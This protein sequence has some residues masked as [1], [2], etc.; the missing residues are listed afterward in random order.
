MG[1]ASVT[2]LGL[3]VSI[4]GDGTPTGQVFAG[5][6][7]GE[8]FIFGSEDGTISGWHTGTAADTLVPGSTAAVYKGVTLAGSGSDMVLLGANFRAGTIDVFSPS[9]TPGGMLTMVGQF[10]DP[11]APAGYA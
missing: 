2:K 7:N 1:M 10:S 3:I 11:K 4:P 9:S 6:F 8:F 5:G